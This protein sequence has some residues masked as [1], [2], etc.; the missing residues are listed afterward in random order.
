MYSIKEHTAD[1]EDPLTSSSSHIS[2]ESK[3][4]LSIVSDSQGRD[5]SRVIN[6]LSNDKITANGTVMPNAGLLYVVDIALKEKNDAIAILGRTNDTIDD[7]TEEVYKQLEG[8]LRTFEENKTI[9]LCTIPQRHD[10]VHNDMVHA[11]IQI[12]NNYI[13]ELVARLENVHLIDTQLL[14]RSCY[15]SHGLHLNNKGKKELARLIVKKVRQINNRQWIKGSSQST[16]SASKV[17][18]LSPNLNPTK[19]HIQLLQSDMNKAI[20]L[21]C[22]NNEVAFAHCIS[23]DLNCDKQMSKGVAVAFK[24]KFGK[25]RLSDYCDMNLTCQKTKH[26]ATVYSL[27]TKQKYFQNS[28]KI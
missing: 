14:K 4:N 12:L 8:K 7:T 19:T 11:D 2:K 23:A 17:T 20:D 5:V 25:P 22:N 13:A 1:A 26:G 28:K 27:V 16:V 3:I 21:Y 18:H 6:Y 10:A 15:T 9:F 24:R